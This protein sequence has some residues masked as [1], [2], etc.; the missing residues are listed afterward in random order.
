MRVSSPSQPNTHEQMVEM[1]QTHT[2]RRSGSQRSD[3]PQRVVP[4]KMPS[5]PSESLY[6]KSALRARCLQA[7]TRLYGRFWPKF[8]NQMH[9]QRNTCSF[10]NPN[11]VPKSVS[12]C[13]NE[14]I[15]RNDSDAMKQLMPVAFSENWYTMF[16]ARH[17]RSLI[18]HM[19]K[20]KTDNE[21]RNNVYD[22]LDTLVR[23]FSSEQIILLTDCLVDNE[24]C[25]KGNHGITG[26]IESLLFHSQ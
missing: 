18:E 11:Y 17:L 26:R 24:S 5:D 6:S 8:S 13:L 23:K 7:T 19:V 16:E 10:Q 21:A 20:E 9:Q 25:V 15:E 14:F 22:L 12:E 1:G 4:N 3:Y 2:I